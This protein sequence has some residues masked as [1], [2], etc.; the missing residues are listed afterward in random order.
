MARVFGVSREIIRDVRRGLRWQPLK[1]EEEKSPFHS[2]DVVSVDRET[3]ATTYAVT[4]ERDH[5]HV[6]GGIVTH[7][8]GRTSCSGPN[9]QNQGKDSGVRECFEPR[10]RMV[11][12]IC[13]YDSQETRTLAQSLL[14]LVGRSSLAEKYKADPDY[15][16]HCDFAAQ[17]M[18]ISYE[19][20]IERKA[21]GDPEMKD[22]RQRAKAAN[23]GF[24]GGLGAKAFVSYALGYGVKITIPEAEAL[25]KAWFASIP[26]MTEY[27]AL[28]NRIARGGGILEQVRSGRLRGGVGFCDG[29][30]SW[31]QGLASEASKTA[32]YFVAKECY[33]NPKSPLYGCR[34]V[35]LIHDELILEAPIE[36]AAAAAA[37]V[38]KQMEAAMALWCPDI[39]SRSTPAL[40]DHWTKD[41]DQCSKKGLLF[42]GR[43]QRETRRPVNNYT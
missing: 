41:A 8:T 32:A 7:N 31:F 42:L 10:P 4:V 29:A 40:C 2:V 9:L 43:R 16:P 36:R 34:P 37:E 21:A 1:P 15:D 19:E 6:T 25:K 22:M 27:F 33:N 23:F 30:N 12:I 26:E 24:P 13:D 35:M 3:S 28:V 20:A 14:D 11:Y 5:S 38:E 17:M 18:G 39:P